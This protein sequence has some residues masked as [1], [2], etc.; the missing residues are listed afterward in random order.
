MKQGNYGWR[1]KEQGRRRRKKETQMEVWVEKGTGHS[2]LELIMYF[3][4]V[5]N[6]VY[7]GTVQNEDL[8]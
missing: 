1:G 3:K 6:R 2:S 8:V 5:F 4:D 7:N